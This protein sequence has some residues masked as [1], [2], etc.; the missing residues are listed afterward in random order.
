M[1]V[2]V[3]LNV[4]SQAP[5]WQW[6]RRTGGAVTCDAWGISTT[7][8]A[9]GNAYTTGYFQGT[10]DF[11]PG[12]GIFNLTSVGFDIFIYKLDASGN[13]IWAKKMG[14][15]FNDIGQS[16][17]ID[18]LGNIYVTGYFNGTADFDPDV[19][20]SYLTSAGSADI[21]I[22]KLNASGNLIWAKSLG[23]IGFDYGYAIAIDNLG[24]LYTTG[25]FRSTADFD[26]NIGIF[27]LTSVGANDIFISKL[28][29]SGNFIWAKAIGGTG[30]DESFSITLDVSS[31]VYITGYFGVTVDFDPG[32]G[33]FN[34]TAVG[35]ED[36]FVSKL[37]DSGN[38]IWAKE[39]GGFGT[40]E[41]LSIAL[42]TLGDVY[43]TGYFQGTVDFDP[44]IGVFNL[45]SGS[46]FETFILKLDNHGNFIWAKSF[47]AISIG[48]GKFIATDAFANVY[49]T[50]NFSG[51]VDFDPGVGI[52]N[53]TSSGQGDIFISKLDSSGSFEWAKAVNGTGFDYGQ[54]IALD[55]SGFVYA[56]GYF[57]SDSIIFGSIILTNTGPGQ[58]DIFIAKLDTAIV[59]INE[60]ENSISSI[61]FYPNPFSE[62]ATL[63][64]NTNS[65]SEGI[66]EIKNIF[67][68]S[69]FP[70]KHFSG[71]TIQ[72]QRNNLSAGIYFYTVTTKTNQIL[73]G[74]FIID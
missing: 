71:N 56:T 24:N 37:D 50:G 22:C 18:A 23:G 20:V 62:F 10:V 7:F 17:I 57:N 29:N 13:F 52:F 6:A 14:G 65:F 27:N 54:S 9:S 61:V 60:T 4:F 74:K 3:S 19:G 63:T 28:D 42:D 49:T 30:Y 8:D 53:L 51:T 66:I 34:L 25:Y 70:S 16:I 15:T 68:A 47:D 67:G 43:A 21:F 31:N 2:I 33:I 44:N 41:G 46:G 36:I 64:L 72:L 1:F 32:V 12:V 26:P 45:I 35:N 69:I 55:A 58:P 73:N 39:I 40:D 38:F 48:Q 5:D 11:D 59:G